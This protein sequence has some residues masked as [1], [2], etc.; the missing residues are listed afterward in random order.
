MKHLYKSSTNKTWEGI[1]GGFGEYFGVDATLLRVLFLV[2]VVCTGIFPGVIIY[3]IAIFII[4]K[5]P[6]VTPPPSHT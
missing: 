1:I 4:P 2:F 5:A 3:I 6:T